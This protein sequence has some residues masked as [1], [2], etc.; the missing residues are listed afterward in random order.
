MRHNETINNFYGQFMEIARKIDLNAEEKF[1]LFI[2]RLI[3]EIATF[4]KGSLAGNQQTLA[5]TLAT[6]QRWD[7]GRKIYD[8]L[9]KEKKKKYQRYREQIIESSNEEEEKS[10]KNEYKK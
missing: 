9:I 3:K 8:K 5:N 6:A 4:I 10:K 2:N 7:E 1:D